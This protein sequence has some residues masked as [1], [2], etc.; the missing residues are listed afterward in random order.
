MA[1]ATVLQE[2][3]S[4][5]AVVLLEPTSFGA[6]G[7]YTAE[8]AGLYS[9]GIAAYVVRL[10]DDIARALSFNALGPI[11]MQPGNRRSFTRPERWGA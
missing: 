6:P 11:A 9:M 4:P 7:D 5:G 10:G 8:L 2:R 1:A 3:N